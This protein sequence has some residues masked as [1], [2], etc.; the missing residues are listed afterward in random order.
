MIKQAGQAETTKDILTKSHLREN[1]K[2]VIQPALKVDSERKASIAER[3]NNSGLRQMELQKSVG[4]GSKFEIKRRQEQ[5]T[6]SITAQQKNKLNQVIDE[7]K[8]KEI[9]LKESVVI[10]ESPKVRQCH[11]SF[12]QSNEQRSRL[13]QN[14]DRKQL[15][16]ENQAQISDA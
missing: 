16:I 4:Y 9:N 10:A 3:S 2:K 12:P 11:S 8:S 6:L 7:I 14:T 13:E 5:R 15:L 1:G